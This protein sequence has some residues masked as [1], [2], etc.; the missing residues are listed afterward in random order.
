MWGGLKVFTA[1]RVLFFRFFYTLVVFQSAFECLR[2]PTFSVEKKWA[3]FLT[4]L[5]PP[6]V[7]I[8]SATRVWCLLGGNLMLYVIVS[9]DRLSVCFCC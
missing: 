5:T 8:S 6:S 4:K 9:C 1:Y 2:R 3:K 7:R